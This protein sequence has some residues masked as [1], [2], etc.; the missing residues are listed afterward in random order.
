MYIV[1]FKCYGLQN[2][3]MGVKYEQRHINTAH[4]VSWKWQV[5]TGT[6]EKLTFGG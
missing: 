2:I 1:Q 4:Q 6:K 3:T 5:N